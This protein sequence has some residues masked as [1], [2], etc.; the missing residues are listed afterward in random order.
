MSLL[1]FTP[2][3]AQ[4]LD[5]VLGRGSITILSRGY[6]NCRI[7]STERPATWHLTYF[8]SQNDVIFRTIEVC[9]VP[10]VA[11][12]AILDL[13]DSEARLRDVLSWLEAS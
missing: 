5:S 13:V 10:E 11:C 7:S 4:Y 3:D 6:G 12:A 2:A 8:N 1:P 9:E